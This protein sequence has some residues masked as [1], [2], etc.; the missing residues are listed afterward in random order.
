MPLRRRLP[1]TY[2]LI[3]L[4]AALALGAALLLILRDYYGRLE[5]DYLERNAVVVSNLLAGTSPEDT[6]LLEKQVLSIAFLTQT[7]IRVFDS[8]ETLIIDTGLRNDLDAMIKMSLAVEGDG[9]TQEFSQILDGETQQIF[10]NSETD[11]AVEVTNG[12]IRVTSSVKGNSAESDT[13]A[14]PWNYSFNATNDARSSVVVRTAIAGLVREYGGHVELSDGPAFGRAI[15]RS[16]AWGLLIAG[17]LAVVLATAVGAI[18]ARRI[19]QPLHDLTLATEQLQSGDLSVRS[20]VK[21]EDEIG[22]LSQTFN[23]MAER[24]E[25]T[26]SSLRHFVADAAHEIHTPITALRTNLELARDEPDNSHF[27]DQAEQQ[28]LRLQHLTNSLLQ[29]SRLEAGEISAEKSPLDLVTLIA[30]R[31]E[32]YASRAEQ[33]GL[34]LTLTQPDTPLCIHG[35]AEQLQRVIDNLLD[36]AIKFSEEDGEISIELRKWAASAQLTVTD[37]GIGNKVAQ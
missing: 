27:I 13:I 11:V 22:H 20:P 12:E 18:I 37:S 25:T 1:L 10:A 3:A 15:V 5:T 21:S 31:S 34:H 2:G 26:V 30:N 33:A 36:N 29:L 32:Q 19:T 6:E 17:T 4:L 28:A 16:V 35:N 14:T 9:I 8:A 23:A 7:R 24:V